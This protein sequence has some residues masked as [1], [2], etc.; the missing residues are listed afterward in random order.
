MAAQLFNPD[1]EED[2]FNSGF[3][4]SGSNGAGA[5]AK[6][7]GKSI[8]SLHKLA[9]SF[10][11]AEVRRLVLCN[12]GL[13]D[14]SVGYI[15]CGWV[16]KLP[17]TSKSHYTCL[18]KPSKPYP[19]KQNAA[20]VDVKPGQPGYT[21]TLT[22]KKHTIGRC[23]S[24]ATAFRI[25]AMHGLLTRWTGAAGAA[26]RPVYWC[27]GKT[28][29]RNDWVVVF[30][31]EYP[32]GVSP[33]VMPC[34]I[35]AILHGMISWMS[36]TVVWCGRTFSKE[37][38][39]QLKFEFMHIRVARNQTGEPEAVILWPLLR[40]IKLIMRPSSITFRK[41]VHPGAKSPKVLWGRSQGVSERSALEMVQPVDTPRNIVQRLCSKV[42]L[43][44]PKMTKVHL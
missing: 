38:I 39:V 16:C 10:H 19:Q 24:Q 31:E 35:H 33:L 36:M 27:F 17:A 29:E 18:D 25:G 14:A 21:S 9:T 23:H 20:L 5:L 1:W 26:L 4:R 32:A 12:S 7:S 37:R 8:K 41:S 6:F 15:D 22:P 28:R 43:V 34:S 13:T 40:K 30:G 42:I 44:V 3:P 2:V 11:R